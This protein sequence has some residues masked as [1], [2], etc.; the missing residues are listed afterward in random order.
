MNTRDRASKRIRHTLS[1]NQNKAND[2]QRRSE[3]SKQAIAVRAAHR[4]TPT[5]PTPMTNGARQRAMMM[6]GARREP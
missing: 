5:P 4:T 1:Q 2:A 3:H 6:T